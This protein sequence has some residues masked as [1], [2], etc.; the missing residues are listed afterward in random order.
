MVAAFG[1]EVV[2]AVKPYTA[3]AV[4]VVVAYAVLVAYVAVVLHIFFTIISILLP[5]INLFYIYRNSCSSQG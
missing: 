1:A 5:D 2:A 4:L 3:A